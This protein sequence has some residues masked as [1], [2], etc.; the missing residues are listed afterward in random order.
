MIMYSKRVGREATNWH[1]PVF[2][3]SGIR[4]I[5]PFFYFSVVV[6]I[7]NVFAPISCS[8]FPLS[9]R[10]EVNR[11][12]LQPRGNNLSLLATPWSRQ[13]AWA[14]KD[15]FDRFLSEAPV[16]RVLCPEPPG[17]GRNHLG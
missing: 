11:L 5:D 8:I 13:G 6:C 4:R 12:V 2:S 15:V 1:H 3:L 10:G 16:R 17:T 14:E 7:K 9:L